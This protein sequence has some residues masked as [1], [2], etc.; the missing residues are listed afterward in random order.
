[1]SVIYKYLLPIL[2]EKL[3]ILNKLNGH[4]TIIG[5]VI[6]M[7]SVVVLAIQQQFP[8]LAGALHIA[9]VNSIL[10]MITGYFVTEL[11]LQHKTSKEI[12]GL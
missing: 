3:P 5:R 10:T 4:K 6:Q 1:M 12:R 9:Q 7:A 8:E 2:F 11:G